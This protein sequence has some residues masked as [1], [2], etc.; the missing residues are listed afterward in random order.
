MSQVVLYDLPSTPPKASWSLNPWKTR[1]ALNFKGVDYRTDWIEYPDLAPKLKSFGLPPNDRNAPGVSADYSSPAI[2]FA[3]DTLMMDSWNIIFELEKRYPEP[4]LHLDD[5]IVL[6]VRDLIA[7]VRDPLMTLTLPKVPDILP[8]RSAQYF[9]D[10]RKVRFGMPLSDYYKSKS[11]EQCWEEVKAPAKQF[12]DLLNSKDGGPFFLGETLSY[13]DFIF[14][15][16]LHFL[17]RV[18]V[19]VFERFLSLDNSFSAIYEASSE[20]LK[21]DD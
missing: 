4:S 21:K 10:T 3:D 11:V 19:D 17:K 6:Q 2:R 5:P 15:A 1:M 18:E 16:F 20:W 7:V 9:Y 14:V 13:A 8:E 12:V